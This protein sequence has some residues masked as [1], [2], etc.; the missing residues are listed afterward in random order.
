MSSKSAPGKQTRT[1]PITRSVPRWRGRPACNIRTPRT[2]RF[3]F[4]YPSG[5]PRFGAE[6]C[7]RLHIH[8]DDPGHALLLH[9][10]ADQLTGHFHRDLVVRDE[11]E[12][13]LLSHLLDHAAKAFG[14]GI[15]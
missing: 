10:D 8:R 3:S 5:G 2:G 12:L 15:V 14:V 13:G 7:R 6:A 9:G 11:Q 4:P 1:W